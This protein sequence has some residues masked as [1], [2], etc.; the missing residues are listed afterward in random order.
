LNASHFRQRA[1]RAREMAQFGDDFRISQMLLEVALDMDTEAAAIEARYPDEQRRSPRLCPSEAYRAL[2]HVVDGDTS[3]RP[4]EII[5]LSFGGAKVR[6]D[7]SHTPGT[8]AVLEIPSQGLR[9]TGR[10]IRVR[11]NE[12]ALAFDPEASSDPSLGELLR[13]LRTAGVATMARAGARRSFEPVSA[14]GV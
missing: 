7:V 14:D 13:S 8:R 3:G 5:D 6:C 2:L 1:A 12:A 4:V 10:I 11:V 9:L